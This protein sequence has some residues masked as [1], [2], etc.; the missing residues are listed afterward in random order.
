MK[1]AANELS[2]NKVELTIEVP[3]EDFEV[4]YRKPTK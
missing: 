2:K 4:S 1:V 3:E